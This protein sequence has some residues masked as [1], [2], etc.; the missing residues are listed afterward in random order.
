MDV[1]VLTSSIQRL[2]AKKAYAYASVIGYVFK[3]LT[4]NYLKA[5]LPVEPVQRT[6]KKHG[7]P[8][9]QMFV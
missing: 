8:K 4:T 3:A 7:S 1:A 5:I 9:G 2:D 6:T